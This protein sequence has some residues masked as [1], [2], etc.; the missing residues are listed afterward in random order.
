VEDC[1]KVLRRLVFVENQS[2]LGKRWFTVRIMPCRTQENR[3][4]RVVITFA[5]ITVAKHQET[6]SRKSQANVEK[7][8]SHQAEELGKSQRI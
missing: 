8:F 1:Q 3:I 5:D 2:S 6:A 7:R 4:S